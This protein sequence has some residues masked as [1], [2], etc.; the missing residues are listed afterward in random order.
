MSHARFTLGCLLLVAGCRG[1]VDGED[2]SRPR[3]AAPTAA[4][5]ASAA[6]AI[7]ELKAP[8][9]PP[10]PVPERL[11]T[12]ASSR[13]KRPA[14]SRYRED[15]APQ[16]AG[17]D[18]LFNESSGPLQGE[19]VGLVCRLGIST[20]NHGRSN[21]GAFDGM[22]DLSAA[23]SIT[24][25]K[26]VVKLDA[27]GP[28]DTKEM[29]FTVPLVTPEKGA[30]LRV[31]SRDRD[32]FSNDPIESVQAT[33]DGSY[34]LTAKGRISQLECR[35]LGRAVVERHLESARIAADEAHAVMEAARPD[36]SAPSFDMKRSQ[37][38]N[39]EGLRSKLDEMAGLVGWDDPRV[40]RRVERLAAQQ[41]RMVSDLGAATE[42][43]G[44][45]LPPSAD[46]STPMADGALAVRVTSYACGPDVAKK[47]NR[48]VSERTRDEFKARPCVLA[49]DVVNRTGAPIE[50]DGSTDTIG[51]LGDLYMLSSTGEQFGVEVF[52]EVRE[53][54]VRRLEYE[55]RAIV[56]DGATV[57][58]VAH[59]VG[60]AELSAFA[61]PLLLRGFHAGRRTGKPREWMS[62]A[63][64]AVEL[65]ATDLTCRDD[66]C[67]LRVQ[68]RLSGR[69]FL[70]IDGLLH[71]I[72]EPQM[73]L[74]LLDPSTFE[75]PKPGK[76]KGDSGRPL[77]EGVT[78]LLFKPFA[79]VERGVVRPFD[80][81]LEV[82]TLGQTVE[83]A[84]EMDGAPLP[85]GMDLDKLV[86][87]TSFDAVPS[88]LRVAPPPAP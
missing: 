15:Y 25:G 42:A 33:F 79:T 19:Q 46:G 9:P 74:M 69:G 78:K 24:Q 52:G 20:T 62:V 66:G 73:R 44:Q 30:K 27:L 4:P 47:Y 36:L 51:P 75:L 54:K 7:E 39:E 80:N 48:A 21:L 87:D 29:W 49:M 81:Y 63:G 72:Q 12:P 70:K 82:T 26:E 41:K 6:P 53:G 13:A 34:P 8:P 60:K 35:P 64:G 76:G 65:R 77:E 71:E 45:K 84:F 23:V 31:T 5:Q 3:R 68:F 10:D 28:E 88:F 16:P 67:V 43:M 38:Q 83:I 1:G 55:Q 32:F 58:L 85:G 18:K 22:A 56:P 57:S 61:P 14:W 37:D 2:A 86:L 59:P 11:G 17:R 40:V 50:V